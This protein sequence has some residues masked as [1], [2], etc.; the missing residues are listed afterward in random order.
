MYA[1]IAS[2]LTRSNLTTQIKA[3]IN[4][5]VLEASK[6]RFYFNEVKGLTFNTVSGTEY[7]ADQ[8][9]TQID[10]M[11]YLDGTTRFELFP[12]NNNDLDLE[13]P[14]TAA[15]GLPQVYSRH[16]NMLRL[17]PIPNAVTAI[18]FD[19]FGRLTPTP[20]VNDA[21]TNAW[22][23]EGE[24]YVRALAKSIILRDVIRDFKEALVYDAIASDYRESLLDITT[25][26]IGT[27]M[28]KATKF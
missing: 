20:L 24:R 17:S 5:A 15:Q 1:R 9:V 10:A 22:M 3:A 21:D 2:E 4:D 27:G 11:Y 6:D 18:Y 7:Y 12:I 8:A 28:I 16:A 23:T 25:Q 13:T 14:G 26:R 19:G